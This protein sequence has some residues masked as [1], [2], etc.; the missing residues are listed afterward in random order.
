MTN[1]Q[2]FKQW[3]LDNYDYDHLQDICNHGCS[4]ACPCG[5]IYYHE[6]MAAYDKYSDEIWETM[7][8][9]AESMGYKSPLEL[10]ASFNGANQVW[11]D[12]TFKNLLVWAFVEEVAN[13]A[14]NNEE[15]YNEI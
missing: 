2:S 13:E 6:T 9:M 1:N 15:A 14:V 10:I 3:I 7:E 11:A 12:A 5:L 4:G 8:K